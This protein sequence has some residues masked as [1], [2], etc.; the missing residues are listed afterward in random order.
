VKYTLG[1]LAKQINGRVH[2]NESIEITG[3]ATLENAASGSIAFLSNRKYYKHLADTRASAVI[4]SEQDLEHCPVAALVVDDVYV[5][6]ARIATL[7]NV[8][9]LPE[10][11]VHASAVVGSHCDIHPGASIGP[12]VFIGDRVSIDQ[13]AV[14]GANSVIEHDSRI[15]S[16][17]RLIA[18][19]TVCHGVEIGSKCLIHPG[20]VIGSDGFGLAMDNG[21]WIKVPQVG[22]VKIGDNVEIGSNTT[23]DRGALDDTVIEE[24]VKLDNQ[25]QIAHNVHI[26]AHTAVAGCVGIA[27]SVKIGKYCGIGG[28][29]MITGHLEIGDNIQI[30]AGTLITK[31]IT[32]PGLYSSGIP[33]MPNTE[34]RKTTARYKK[35][36]ELTRRV[37][38]LEKD[39]NNKRN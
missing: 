36:D 30:T 19:I 21:V 22:A 8:Q 32:E 24:G 10:A 35:L 3:V 6:Y 20:V 26:G 29:A 18:N 16:D 39:C 9:E 23:I 12:N 14:I 1:D 33:A 13:G 25:I 17:T 2:G 4:L 5:S 34:W 38:A 37:I 31:S 7:F 28:A 11:G 15:G 27:G